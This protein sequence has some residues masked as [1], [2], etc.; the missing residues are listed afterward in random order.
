MQYIE[1][2]E[3][4]FRPVGE[5]VHSYDAKAKAAT[6]GSEASSSTFEIYTVSNMT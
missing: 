3:A 5:K 6:P 1:E 4:K 2:K